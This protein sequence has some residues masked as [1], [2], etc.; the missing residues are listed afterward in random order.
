MIPVVTVVGLQYG[1]LLG[2]AV[3]TETIF[4]WPGVG[5]LAM[6]SILQRDYPVVQGCV[7]LVAVV[8]VLVNLLVDLLYGWLDPRIRYE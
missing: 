2:G 7:L 4:A 5:R 1:F 3:V 6:T 8:F